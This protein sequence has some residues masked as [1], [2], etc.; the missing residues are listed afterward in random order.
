VSSSACRQPARA[1]AS[2]ASSPTASAK[3]TH[4]ANALERELRT[5]VRAQ[6]PCLLAETGCAALTAATLIGRSANAQRFATDARFARH[7]GT[8]P[9]PASPGNRQRHRL[10]PGGDRQLNRALHTIAITIRCLKRH[11]ARRC[12]RLLTEP[13][14]PPP[15]HD[16]ILTG[17]PARMH[18]LT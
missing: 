15:S 18:C 12:Y 2:R 4:Q 13:T 11:L 3:L 16:P 6:R 17:A 1:C 5:L 8:A 9:I 7:T 10:H 14:T